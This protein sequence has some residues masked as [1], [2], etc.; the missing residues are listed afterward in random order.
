MGGITITSE[1][2]LALLSAAAIAFQ[3]LATAV[4]PGK[5]RA[6]AFS[7][8][9]LNK[10]F[11]EQHKKDFG[12]EITKGGYPDMGSGRYSD[13]LT[14]KEWYEFNNAQRAHYN[15]IEQIGPILT[16]LLVAAIRLP[17]AAGWLGLTYCVGRLLYTIGYVFKGPKGRMIGVLLVDVGLIGLVGTAFASAWK[18][19][20]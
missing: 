12:V 18:L 10:H 9:F 20:F 17:T 4:A 19:L 13:K 2:G 15:F 7:Q 1:Y 5:G 3:C 6:K 11:G 16:L 8:E 14:Y